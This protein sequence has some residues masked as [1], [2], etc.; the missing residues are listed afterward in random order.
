MPNQLIRA[1]LHLEMQKFG[2]KGL[3]LSY[4][5][6]RALFAVQ[7]MLDDTDYNGNID[8]IHLTVEGYTGTIPG[9]RFKPAEYLEAYGLT[10]YKT[11]RN[12]MEYS[13]SER[14]MAIQALKKLASRSFLLSYTKMTF[15][16]KKCDNESVTLS[17][18]S[19]LVLLEEDRLYPSPILV[20][21]IDSYFVWLPEDLYKTL[22]TKEIAA[23]LFIEYLLTQAEQIRRH[24]GKY[25]IKINPDIMAHN[26]RLDSFIETRQ[27]NRIRQKLNDLYLI[28]QE[29]GYLSQYATDQDGMKVKKID[30]L[31]LNKQKLDDLRYGL[32][33]AA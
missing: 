30:Q 15:G 3:D 33:M 1:S 18:Q 24:H 23:V 29:R 27:W 11:A 31:T 4:A 2:N 16:K 26:L 21:Q 12:K 13:G 8:S 28:G 20:D 7:K 10:K 9:I 17:Y 14:K 6:S 25:L 5:E 32:R 19:T 22:P